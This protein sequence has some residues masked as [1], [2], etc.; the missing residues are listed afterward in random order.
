MT[1]R[2]TP[3]GELEGHRLAE[4]RIGL[5]TPVDE[6][7]LRAQLAA[8]GEHRIAEPADE[9]ARDGRV[10]GAEGVGVAVEDRIDRGGDD[11]RRQRE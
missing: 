11:D 9:A 8:V 1:H 2:D 7:G 4:P 3:L 6:D 5:S 10:R